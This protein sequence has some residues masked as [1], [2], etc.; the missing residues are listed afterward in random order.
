MISFFQQ[1]IT[2]LEQA[3]QK[4][5]GRLRLHELIQ[6]EALQASLGSPDGRLQEF[7]ERQGGA[8]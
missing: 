4:Y 7:S 5:L 8:E 3:A 2:A 6:A 1:E